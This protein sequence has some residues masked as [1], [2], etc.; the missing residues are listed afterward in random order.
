MN[1]N[2]NPWK[3]KSPPQKFGVWQI[4]RLTD[5][6]Y[7][8]YVTDTNSQKLR[9]RERER[10]YIAYTCHWCQL[11]EIKRQADI[12]YSLSHWCQLSVPGPFR[13]WI[14]KTTTDIPIM[15][16]MIH[17]LQPTTHKV[18]KFNKTPCVAVIK[19]QHFRCRRWQLTPWH[20]SPWQLLQRLNACGRLGC[21]CQ[22]YSPCSVLWPTALL[23]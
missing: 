3:I 7:I 17:S 16:C 5:M 4:K 1:L 2:Y 11:S 14:H 9:E 10:L 19:R 6:L 18:L 8:A 23:V 21:D 13:E 15:W 22:F 20:L 12:W